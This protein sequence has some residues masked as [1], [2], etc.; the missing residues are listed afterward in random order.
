MRSGG[1]VSLS[2]ARRAGRTGRLSVQPPGMT[3]ATAGVAVEAIPPAV[4][5]AP[6]RT[7]PVVIAAGAVD[8]PLAAA[9][10]VVTPAARVRCIRPF[11]P[12]VAG[13]RKS[14]SSRGRTSR[15][16]A[17]SASSCDVR[18]RRRGATTTSTRA[19]ASK[20]MWATHLGRPHS[21]QALKPGPFTQVPGV[22]PV[23]MPA[24]S[25]RTPL[26]QTSRTPVE[27]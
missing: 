22:A 4:T 8:T 1:S 26:T 3:P 12:S 7:P 21:F 10:G 25:T 15:C 24:F 16:T 13:R 11:A 17:V 2:V 14:P 20:L 6:D 9:A 23:S 19:S 18:Q 27:S 5:A